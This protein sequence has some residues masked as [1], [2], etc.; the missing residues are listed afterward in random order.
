MAHRAFCSLQFDRVCT[1]NLD[2]LLESEYRRIARHCTPLI[3][4]AQLSINPKKSWVGLVK[5]HG[6]LHHPDRLVVTERDYDLFLSRFLVLAAFMTNLMVTRTPV[7]IGYSL[8]DPDLRQLWQIIGDHLGPAR[9][10]AY[11]IMVEAPPADVARFARRGVAVVNLPGTKGQYGE[12]LAD[13]FTELRDYWEGSSAP[14]THARSV[15]AVALQ[16]PSGPPLVASVRDGNIYLRAVPTG[17]LCQLTATGLDSDARLSPDGTLIVFVRST[18]DRT[19]DVGVGDCEASELWVIRIDGTD[20]KMVISGGAGATAETTRAGFRQPQF[21]PD[22]RRIYFLSQAWVTSGAVHALD[23]DT[24]LV[25]FVC[26]GNSLEVIPSGEY[27]GHLMVSQHRYFFGG[28]S[29]DWLWLVSPDG[30]ML[31]P[32][33]EDQFRQLF[34][35]GPETD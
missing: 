16:K 30:E 20:A 33:A 25:R 6:D 27:R 9:R 28:G 32:I 11:A 1:T 14:A 26:P 29:Y 15:K 22:G 2:F 12:I 3:D 10:M 31:G 34:L 4:E 8:D 17:E 19:V 21:S 7:L 24:G 18:P 5:L 35:A 23:L 13:A